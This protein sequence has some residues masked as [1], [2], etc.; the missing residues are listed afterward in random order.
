MAIIGKRTQAVIHKG[1]INRLGGQEY[2]AN[3]QMLL[4][5]GALCA[6]CPM[7]Q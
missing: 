2:V 4:T 3:M 7:K 1:D 5:A 6:I